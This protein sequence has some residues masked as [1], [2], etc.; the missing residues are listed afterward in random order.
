MPKK[1]NGVSSSRTYAIWHDMRRRCSNPRRKGYENYGGRGIKVCERWQ[2][3]AHFL[4]DMGDA[5][6]GKSI[7]RRDVNGD[8]TPSNCCWASKSEQNDNTTR[9]VKLT[10]RG[11]KQSL[12]DWAR[13]LGIAQSAL[14]ARYD[15]GWSA[16]R[17]LDTPRRTFPDR[18]ATIDGVT[19]SLRNWSKTTGIQY[20]S[21][22]YR[23]RDPR[24][25][26]AKIVYGSAAVDWRRRIVKNCSANACDQIVVAKGFCSKHYQQQKST[27][28]NHQAAE[29]VL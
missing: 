17:I 26:D 14:R 6:I 18:F 3:F 22:L 24:A 15:K 12:K 28:Q 19:Q 25:S 1:C 20:K 21:M 10:V 5:P 23:A 11:R 4:V 8:Y 16:E 29:R 9:T 2:V 7:E 27:Q 13:E